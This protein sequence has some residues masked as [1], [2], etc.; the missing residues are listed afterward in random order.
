MNG[1]RGA[2]RVVHSPLPVV[3]LISGRGS[4]LQ[5]I[6]DKTSSGELPVEIR[7]VISNRP[8]ATG[9]RLAGQAG[10]E[11]RVID[12]TDYADRETFDRALQAC[13]DSYRPG[14]VVLAGFMRI[15]TPG[16][17]HHYQGRMLNIHPSLL[18]EFPGR[19]T[20][21]RAIDA[22]KREHGASVHFV[23]EDIDG[24]PVLLQARIPVRESD[25]AA[26]LAERVLREEHRLFP[27]AIRWFAQGRIFLDEN[28]RIRMD[29]KLLDQPV[30][31]PADEAAPC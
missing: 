1:S 3:I 15:L 16:F 19:N 18:P 5:A 23:T 22:G 17:V 28:G 9:L 24:G 6:I 20:H 27:L 25:N 30:L 7:A 14:L 12:H 4:N 29:E 21:Q 10:L 8:D 31:L 13:I 26:S 11:T 2:G